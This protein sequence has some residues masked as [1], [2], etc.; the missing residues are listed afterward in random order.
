MAA[1]TH[2]DAVVL[3]DGLFMP[4]RQNRDE[5]ADPTIVMGMPAYVKRYEGTKLSLSL[6]K[7]KVTVHWYWNERG[8]GVYVVCNRYNKIVERYDIRS[9]GSEETAIALNKYSALV[10]DQVLEILF[11]KYIENIKI[12]EEKIKLLESVS[13]EKSKTLESA[14][15]L[16]NVKRS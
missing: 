15:E 8:R 5:L 1:P 10:E 4:F 3:K 6:D 14:L 11:Q 13:Q 7:S 2:T 9:S 12:L 16:L